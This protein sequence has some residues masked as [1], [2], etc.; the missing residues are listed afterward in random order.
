[1]YHSKV[2]NQASTTQKSYLLNRNPKKH[3]I[4][5]PVGLVAVSFWK[6]YWISNCAISKASPF[7]PS[8][9]FVYRILVSPI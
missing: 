2:Q 8:F 7:G 9:T 6:P 3:S 1:M 5:P 4:S